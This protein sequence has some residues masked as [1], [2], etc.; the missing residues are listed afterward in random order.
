MCELFDKMLKSGSH[1][2]EAIATVVVLIKHAIISFK[3]GAI[4][5]IMA[6][7]NDQIQGLFCVYEYECT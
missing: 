5:L 7:T 4:I 3:T 6:K 2:H 1:A